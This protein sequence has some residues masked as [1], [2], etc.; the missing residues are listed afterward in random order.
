MY[1]SDCP[2]NIG[3]MAG[4]LQRANALPEA[5]RYPVRGTHAQRIFGL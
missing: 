5:G 2:F 4:C 1:D 3:D